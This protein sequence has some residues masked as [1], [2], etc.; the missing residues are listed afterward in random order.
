MLLSDPDRE[1][2]KIHIVKL[3]CKCGSVRDV[4]QQLC[5]ALTLIAASDFPSKWPKLLPE[6]VQHLQSEDRNTVSGMLLA[7]NSIMKRFRNASK[8]DGL[9]RELEDSI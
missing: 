5:Q 9:Y 7:A 8:T 3:V 2:I 4:K 1:D 6:V